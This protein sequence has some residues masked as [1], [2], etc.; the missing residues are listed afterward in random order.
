MTPVTVTV[1]H[2]DLVALSLRYSLDVR[3][4]WWVLAVVSVLVGVYFAYQTGVP[5]TPRAWLIVIAIGLL[6]AL[7]AQV[8][9]VV[10]GLVSVAF[11]A[12]K[13]PGVLGAHEYTFTDRGLFERTTANETLIKWGGVRSV[14]RHAGLLEIE[15]SPA[16]FHL[17]PRRAFASDNDYIAFCQHAERLRGAVIRQG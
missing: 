2:S 11:L 17:I 15:V 14:R 13:I 4:G 7:A 6:G 3:R 10:V 12:R 5:S 16:A 8:G 1:T 9:T